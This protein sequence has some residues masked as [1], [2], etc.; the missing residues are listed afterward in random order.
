MGTKVKYRTRFEQ[1]VTMLL[2]VFI[3]WLTR[4]FLVRLNDRIPVKIQL[5]ASLDLHV[6]ADDNKYRAT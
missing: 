5:L 6:N 4:V 2:M 1:L 3:E